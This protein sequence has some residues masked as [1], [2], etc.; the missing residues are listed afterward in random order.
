MPNRAWTPVEV[1]PYTGKILQAIDFYDR[2]SGLRARVW[3]RFI[4]TGAGFGFWGKVVASLFTTASLVL[5]YTGFALAW[6]RLS[7]KLLSSR[8]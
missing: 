6:R 5:I 2:S 4:H 1:D 8:A 7:P 3:I